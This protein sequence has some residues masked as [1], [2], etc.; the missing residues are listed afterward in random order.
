M[1]NFIPTIPSLYFSKKTILLLF[2]FIFSFQLMA[3]NANNG[4]TIASDQSICPGETPAPFTSVAPA[5]G[6]TSTAPIEYLWMM[7]VGNSAT[8]PLSS[9]SAAPGVNNQE[10][11]SPPALG[12]T[13]FFVRCARRQSYIP[14]SAESN[15]LKITVLGFPTAIING[16]TTNTLHYTSTINLNAAYSFGSTY[17]WDFDEDGVTDCVGQNCSF[18]YTNTGTYIISL[19]VDNGNCSITI[20]TTVTILA[21]ANNIADPCSCSDPLNYSTGGNYYVHDY[22]HIRSGSGQTWT[23]SNYPLGKIYDNSGNELAVGT[24]IPQVASGEYYLNIWFKSGIGYDVNVVNNFFTTLN[25]S[26]TDACFCSSPLPIELISFDAFVNEDNVTLKW[27]TASENNNSFFEIERSFDG[28]RFDFVGALESQGNSNTNQYYSLVDENKVVG[29]IYYRLKQIDLDGTYTYSDIVAIHNDSE[30][31]IATVIP[32][33]ITD[34]AIVKFGNELPE[35]TKLQLLSAT[36]QVLQ[37]LYITGSSQEINMQK[38][39][40]GIYFLRIKNA[41]KDQKAFYKIIKI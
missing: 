35:R 12:L 41:K 21:F 34:R 4:G 13:T 32:N 11:Y 24:T 2:Y 31:I 1:T 30:N 40:R 6:G 16:N 37:T 20:T 18:T 28:I 38:L 14:Y 29:E 39:E 5:S 26:T 27:V 23:T 7:I 36:G 25:T 9:W 19:T 15:P 33:P 10:T 17:S 3:Q 8:L 22:I